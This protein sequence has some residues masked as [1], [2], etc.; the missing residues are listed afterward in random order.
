MLFQVDLFPLTTSVR[1]AFPSDF[2]DMNGNLYLGFMEF[3]QNSSPLIK[4][5][6]IQNA[7][8]PYFRDY[9]FSYMIILK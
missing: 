8:N 9:L 1:F 5:L 6:I 4:S 7:T 3:S 2:N